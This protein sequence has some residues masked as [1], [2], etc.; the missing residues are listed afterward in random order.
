MTD[1]IAILDTSVACCWLDVPGRSAA[2]SGPRAWNSIRAKKAVDDIIARRGTLI[3]P[4][5][6]LIES[7]NH[8]SQCGHSRRFYATKLMDT[9]IEAEKGTVPWRQFNEAERLWNI[10]WYANAKEHWPDYADRKVG[11]ADFSIIS[12]ANYFHKLGSEVITLTADDQIHAEVGHLVPP[13]PSR[14]RRR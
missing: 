11:L 10:D 1:L 9:V 5:A 14:R 12:I 8:I 6:V 7:A 4:R 13:A 2:G 3:L